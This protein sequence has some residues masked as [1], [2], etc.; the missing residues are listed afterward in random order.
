MKYIVTVLLLFFI[1]SLNAKLIISPFDAMKIAY[2]DDVEISKKNIL[3]KKQQ[4]KKILKD[5][6]VR[7]LHSKIIRVFKAEKNHALLGYGVLIT[8]VMR[9][10]TV[11]VLYII[12][13]DGVLQSS[14]IIAFN[15]PAEYMPSKTWLKQFK[16][17]STNKRLVVSKDIPTITGATLTARGLV[18]GSRVAFAFYKEIL[19]DEK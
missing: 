19:E 13:K 1:T 15:E 7:K 9:T 2:G 4:V 6:K 12:T 11:T 10:K 16:N 14:E 17:I 8:R 5:A 18:D 3:L